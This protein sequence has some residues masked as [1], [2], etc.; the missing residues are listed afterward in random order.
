MWEV[1]VKLFYRWVN[2]I[3]Q[4]ACC[5]IAKKGQSWKSQPDLCLLKTSS[6]FTVKMAAAKTWNFQMRISF[7]DIPL[8]TES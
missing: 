5:Q 1:I 6:F 4:F 7:L 2:K 3:K 8:L